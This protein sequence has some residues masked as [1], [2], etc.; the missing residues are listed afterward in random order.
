M[1]NKNWDS[2]TNNIPILKYDSSAMQNLLISF[3]TITAKSLELKKVM[4]KSQT[5]PHIDATNTKT[6]RGC[7]LKS[8]GLS[9]RSSSVPVGK[10]LKLP[11][12]GL[13]VVLA[14]P[15]HDTLKQ[16]D[17]T[18][19]KMARLFNLSMIAV[20]KEKGQTFKSLDKI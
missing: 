19:T 6:R 14:F 1:Y 18:K 12:P 3:E 13:L 8:N 10:V 5:L 15:W 17:S 4:Y 7:F 2:K 20:C 16:T 9:F 11:P